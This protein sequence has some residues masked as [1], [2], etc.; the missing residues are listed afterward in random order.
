MNKQQAK[1]DRPRK[2]GS[3]LANTVFEARCQVDFDERPGAYTDD[4]IIK[5]GFDAEGLPVYLIELNDDGV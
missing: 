3:K 4:V 5:R 2:S 1:A